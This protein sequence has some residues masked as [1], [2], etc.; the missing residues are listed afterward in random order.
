LHYLHTEQSF[1]RPE[2]ELAQTLRQRLLQIDGLTQETRA[3]LQE[4]I[5]SFPGNTLQEILTTALE[6]NDLSSFYRDLTDYYML[7]GNPVQAAY[8]Y[9]LRHPHKPN[10]WTRRLLRNPLVESSLRK[11]MG[12]L[13]SKE[14]L[15]PQERG[16]LWQTL[17]QMQAQYES[18]LRRIYASDGVQDRLAFYDRTTNALEDFIRQNGRV[19]KR[20]TL[21]P[22]ERELYNDIIFALSVTASAKPEP[23]AG[24]LNQLQTVWDAN[25]PNWWTMEETLQRFENFLKKHPLDYPQS[26]QENP[27]VSAEETE[28]LEN[29]EHWFVDG[30][31]SFLTKINDLRRQYRP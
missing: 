23:Y 24:K 13:L 5:N 31:G 30:P 28:L 19:P 26:V 6:Q 2:I 1:Y 16:W 7:D 29:I 11:D 9:S 8:N 17:T 14:E 25:Q 15:N 22:A 3:E 27:H 4:I 10:L 18:N 12:H 20:N 21:D